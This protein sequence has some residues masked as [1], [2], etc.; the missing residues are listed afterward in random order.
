MCRNATYCDYS[1]LFGV[2]YWD[3]Y[4]NDEYETTP[5]TG[6]IPGQCILKDRQSDNSYDCVDRSDETI[7]TSHSDNTGLNN[8]TISLKDKECIAEYGPGI[9]CNGVC[10]EVRSWCQTSSDSPCPN[11]GPG[12]TMNS[13]ILCS[14]YSLWED[15]SCDMSHS[16]YGQGERCTGVWP[17]QCIYPHNSGTI[18]RSCSDLSDQI[19]N[20]N[21]TCPV[22]PPT[23]DRAGQFS[24][25]DKVC[26]GYYASVSACMRCLDPHNCYASCDITTAWQNCR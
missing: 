24:H 26:N 6:A 22:I 1:D 20:V 9:L 25:C 13:D 12:I 23:L 3:P 4:T 11:I 2:D 10:E 8:Q 14:D 18:P 15:I 17:G 21:S 16:G 7:H 19:H 5:C